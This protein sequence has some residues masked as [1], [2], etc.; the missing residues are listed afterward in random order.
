MKLEYVS[1][2][3]VTDCVAKDIDTVSLSNLMSFQ[4]HLANTRQH[5][6]WAMHAKVDIDPSQPKQQFMLPEVRF[7]LTHTGTNEVRDNCEIK[8]LGA[9]AA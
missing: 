3:S 8:M 4:Y 5:D 7:K 2:S 9:P 1:Q 6:Q